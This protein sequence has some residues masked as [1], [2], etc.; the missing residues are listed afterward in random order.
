MTPETR[1]Q[2]LALNRHFYATF[3]ASFAD[4]RSSPQPGF[5]RLMAYLP[6]RLK[7]VADIGC[8][9]GR[10]G[11]Y[12]RA[13]KTDFAYTGIDF[14]PEFLSL[15]ASAIEG[16]YLLR[17]LSQGSFLAEQGQFDLCVCLA[18]LQHIPGYDNRQAL[19]SEMADHLAPGGRIFLSNW[20]FAHSERQQRKIRPWSEAGL[21]PEAVEKNDFLLS[22]RRD[23]EGLRYVHSLD[24][25]AIAYLARETDLSIVDEFCSDGREGN[26]N[27][28]SILAADGDP[29]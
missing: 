15:A 16:T 19:L 12:L 13:R 10:F 24:R 7:R 29:R 5:E 3:A 8:G 23:G 26:L 6:Q 21:S 28:Y 18:T 9:N 4:S 20:Q 2:L 1:Q 22:W 25:A 14:T 11:Q 17:D 27:L